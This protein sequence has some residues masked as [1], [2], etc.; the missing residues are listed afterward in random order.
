MDLQ[1]LLDEE[2]DLGN[3]RLEVRQQIKLHR[4]TQPPR[5]WG[6]DDCST[7]IMVKCPWRIDC[8]SAE[9]ERHWSNNEA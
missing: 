9:A 3:K 4:G 7:M 1:K 2:A 8:D 5:C 6:T